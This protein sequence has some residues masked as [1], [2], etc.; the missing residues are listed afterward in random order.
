MLLMT[1]PGTPIFFAGDEIGMPNAEVP[2][3]RVRDPFEILVPGHGLNRDPERAPL[4]WD[5]GPQAGFTDGEPW[6]PLGDHVA[7]RNVATQ[8]ADPRSLLWLY[9]RLLDLRR[10]EPALVA[11]SYAPL[12]SQVEVL[13]FE[14]RLGARRLLVALNLGDAPRQVRIDGCGALRLS[15]RVERGD[16][17]LGPCLEL[18]PA[19]G[20]ILEMAG[21]TR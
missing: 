3:E 13:L 11:G 1:L 17:A 12:R 9:R 8:R 7:E 15:T 19:E 21:E 6:L 2:P 10:R 18:G 16:A 5:D 20:V 14:R 4:R